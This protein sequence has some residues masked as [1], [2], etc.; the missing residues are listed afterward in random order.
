MN[1]NLLLFSLHNSESRVSI[2]NRMVT[3]ISMT[4]KLLVNSIIVV[5]FTSAIGFGL[6]KFAKSQNRQA[7]NNKAEA[8]N[9]S[10]AGEPSHVKSKELK[11]GHTSRVAEQSIPARMTSADRVFESTHRQTEILIPKLNGKPIF[12]QTFGLAPNGNIWACV[13]GPYL[14]MTP[15]EEFIKQKQKSPPMIQVYSPSLKLVQQFELPFTATAINFDSAENVFYI[16]GEGYLAKVDLKG[17]IL[18]RA[19]APNIESLPKLKDSIRKQLRDDRQEMIKMNRSQK[20]KLTQ[21]IADI[22]SRQTTGEVSKIDQK[23]LESYT[24]RLK[25][26]ENQIADFERRK[27]T[28]E[29]IEETLRDRLIIK[30][31]AVADNHLFVALLADDNYSYEV[32]RINKQLGNSKKILSEMRGCCGRFDIKSDG[33]D[34]WVADNIFF[35]VVKYDSTGK[36]LDA[37]GHK[38]TTDQH[39]FG[40]CCNPMNL[41]VLQNGDILT[42][43][44]SIGHIKRFSPDGKLL[45]YIGQAKIG[46]GCKNVAV[47]YDSK[48]NIYYM[49]SQD[50]HSICVL[51]EK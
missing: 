44:S 33:N 27:I 16:G 21:R 26:I 25:E 8:E 28:D 35:R 32:F 13:G 14:F 20:Q 1:H 40:S 29:V 36:R 51:T 17:K 24:K 15:D 3:G 6:F 4:K 48:R 7:R 23:R 47:G 30:A 5:L 39:G 49:L 41:Q 43:E 2:E 34:V 22:K 12:L 19:P 46:G 9:K 31:I 38:S 10:G 45:G 50:D 37:F 11:T 42:A 18:Q